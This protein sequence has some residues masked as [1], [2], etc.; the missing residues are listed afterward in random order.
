MIGSY[1]IMQYI[2]PL[3]LQ[4]ILIGL[5][6]VFAAAETAFL[7]I[8]SAKLEKIAEEGSKKVKKKVKRL[9]KFTGDSSKFLST[10]QVAITLAGFL[11]SAFA[12]DSFAEPLTNWFNSLG[13]MVGKGIYIP[14][15]VFVI[16]ITLLLSFFSIVF[17][18][19]IPKKLAIKHAEGYSL[20]ICGFI[21]VFAIVF[22][23]F[24][25]ILTKTTNGILRL[26]G[27]NPH[28]EEEAASEEEIRIMLD[29]SSEAGAIDSMENEMIQN[30]FEFDD[31]LISEV[32]T[33]RRDVKMIYRDDTL[34]DWKQVISTSRHGYYPICGE[35]AD[36]IVA[37]LNIKKFFRAECNNVAEAMRIA[38]EK[39]YFVP[40]NMKADVLF[41]NMK[42]TRN[43][44]AIVVDEYGGTNGVIT[45]HDLLELLVGDMDE[46]DEVVVEKIVCLNEEA[47]EWKILGSA[48][49]TEVGEAFGITFDTE[50]CDTFGG[51]I[52]GILGE[53]PDDGSTLDLETD[54]LIIKVESVL[55]HR[56]ES[57]LVTVKERPVDESGEELDEDEKEE[58]RS[59]KDKEKDDDESED[60][61]S[62]SDKDE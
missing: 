32:C 42:E 16:L 5:N 29:T 61:E 60:A 31:I 33:H 52:F 8:N 12:A 11:G 6:A 62:E 56:I 49:L 1:I 30:I 17:G 3:L 40:E 26:F 36:D 13:F 4:F 46:K 21:R 48:S 18:E 57:T 23:V 53:I 9:E 10:I 24:V 15:S 50:D 47:R 41:S 45:I 14:E 44:F 54:D 43:Y 59:K 37:V 25:W 51:Y 38:S 27:V 35:S 19:L 55:D 58:K 28:E 20:A 34:E 7:S 22:S 2:V 39:P